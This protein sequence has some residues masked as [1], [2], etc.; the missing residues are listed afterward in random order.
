MVSG[1][2]N[3]TMYGGNG[4]DV[5]DHRAFDG[6]YTFNMST[7]LTNY[8]GELYLG[9]E[10]VYMGDGNDQVTGTGR[11]D[12]IYGGLGNDTL[13]GGLS[14]A[15]DQVYGGDGS[16]RIIARLGTS[17]LDGGAGIDT[18]DATNLSG[19]V[20]LDMGTGVTNTAGQSFTGF[21]AAYMGAG[22]DAITGSGTSDTIY[23]GLGNDTIYGGGGKD[24]LY[25]DGGNDF[26]QYVFGQGYDDIYGG[27]GADK[28]VLDA[29]F[30]DT[31]TIDLGAG[32]W[33]VDG[34]LSYAF[35]SIE[36][37]TTAD[38]A[39]SVT[40]S[41]ANNIIT[42][43]AGND[44]ANGLAGD[45][46][47]HGDAGND[48]LQGGIGNDKL[49]GGTENDTL[50][51]NA[52]DDT[53]TGDDG[54]DSLI[55]ADGN[56]SLA[57]STGDDFL[58]GGTGND[59]LNGGTGNDIMDGGDGDDTFIVAGA[60][61]IDRINHFTIAG[62]TEVINLSGVAAITSFADLVANHLSMVGGNAVI[63]VGVN[64]LTLG[65]ILASSLQADDFVF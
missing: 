59:T 42:L 2:G 37:V 18:L 23:G 50:T 55:G 32:T 65:G 33:V 9:Y 57:G 38:G 44:T 10:I 25:G 13:A 34:S 35:V 53:L 22:N 47:I 15:G 40:G 43:G 31:H 19:G 63:T 49:R 61:G 4:T 14:A 1:L 27:G 29:F 64:T 6:D 56:D 20:V 11:D 17:T 26:F 62:S 58:F 39:D 52:G 16:D 41:G 30:G 45:D 48:N 36:Q 46:V 28:V 54:N 5:I 12:V 8:V 24:A 7:G 60:F 21:E 51:G 3:E